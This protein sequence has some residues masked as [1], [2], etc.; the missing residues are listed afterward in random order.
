M[1]F[2]VVV[3]CNEDGVIGKNG[4]LPWKFRQDMKHF[5]T[6]TENNIVIMGRKTYESIGHA[7]PNRINIVITSNPNYN[8]HGCEIAHSLKE[9]MDMCYNKDW[10]ID[11]KEEDYQINDNE[12]VSKKYRDVFIIGGKR[13]IEEALPLVGAVFKTAVYMPIEIDENTVTITREFENHMRMAF[14]VPLA[15]EVNQLTPEDP[16]LY[17]TRVQ[18]F[19]RA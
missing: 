1:R 18:M 11:S 10:M 15:P 6:L 8:A 3:A 16:T 12:S 17:E 9:A 7:L 5:K 13:V 4:K 14:S 19:V 2:A